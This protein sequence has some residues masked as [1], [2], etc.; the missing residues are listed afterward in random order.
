MNLIKRALI[1][2]RREKGKAL[3]LFFLVTI[4]GSLV[5]GG[6]LVEQAIGNVD[7]VV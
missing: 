5:V 3:I 1:Y 7:G 2:L 6:I 4:L